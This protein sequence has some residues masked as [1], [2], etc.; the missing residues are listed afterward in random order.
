[1]ELTC[2]ICPLGCRVTIDNDSERISGQGCR[3][4]AEYA[5]AEAKDPRRVLTAVVAVKDRAQMLSVKTTHP[6]PKKLLLTAMESIRTLQA[7]P[8]IQIGEVIMEDLA[9]TGVKLIAT[10]TMD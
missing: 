4:G 9:G 3:R 8:P 10:K 6:I 1:M 2:I 7:I 5:R